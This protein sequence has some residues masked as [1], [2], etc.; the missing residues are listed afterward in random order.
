MVELN[1]GAA[2][3]ESGETPDIE[4]LAEGLLKFVAVLALL[5]CIALVWAVRF[6]PRPAN[7]IAVAQATP[8]LDR[9]WRW[10]RPNERLDGMYRGSR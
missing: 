1:T 3:D 4:R 8:D 10:S 5:L 7:A 2:I 9:E 6:E